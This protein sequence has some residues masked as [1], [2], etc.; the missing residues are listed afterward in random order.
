MLGDIVLGAVVGSTLVPRAAAAMVSDV[1]TARLKVDEAT[2]RARW[3][4]LV[5][6][7]NTCKFV[8]IATCAAATVVGVAGG[9]GP[10]HGGTGGIGIR[11]LALGRDETR[12]DSNLLDRPTKI[13]KTTPCKVAVNCRR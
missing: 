9:V 7:R 13:S 1:M 6:G 8:R 3:P 5:K 12:S 10:P 4:K 11:R 2:R